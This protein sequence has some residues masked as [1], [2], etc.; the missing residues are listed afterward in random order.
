MIIKQ[1]IL[2]DYWNKLTNLN[3]ENLQLE[4][5]YYQSN[6]NEIEI[7]L[8]KS[9]KKNF[10]DIHEFIVSIGKCYNWH[11]SQLI[12][13]QNS[14]DTQIEELE[15]NSYRKLDR[16]E[17]LLKINDENITE[18]SIL[19]QLLDLNIEAINIYLKDYS[20]DWKEFFI[21]TDKFY[22]YLKLNYN[23]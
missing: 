14:N 7:N 12:T 19:K 10:E 11:L 9:P 1:E 13:I 8:I 15:E 6:T 18:K 20:W 22:F 3:C 16:N 23:W 2:I 5:E 21:E 17:Y 4:I